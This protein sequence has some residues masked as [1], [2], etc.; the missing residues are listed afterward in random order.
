M[1]GERGGNTLNVFTMP[2]ERTL[3]GWADR[4]SERCEGNGEERTLEGWA[5]RRSERCEG[6]GEVTRSMYSP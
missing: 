3:E 5:D 6:K 2:K 1:R 4:R